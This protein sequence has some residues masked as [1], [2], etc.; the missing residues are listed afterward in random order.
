VAGGREI[1]DDSGVFKRGV[2]I[3]VEVQNILKIEEC[4][5]CGDGSGESDGCT[6]APWCPNS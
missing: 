5:C 4:P 1:V 3:V 2:E 6:C